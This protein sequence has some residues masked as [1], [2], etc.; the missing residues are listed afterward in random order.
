MNILTLI[1]ALSLDL[2]VVRSR[3]VSVSSQCD[4]DS[5]QTRIGRCVRPWLD[6][7][8]MIRIREPQAADLVFPVSLQ[9]LYIIHSRSASISARSSTEYTAQSIKYT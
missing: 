4:L 9:L 6:L 2:I 5:E 3:T 8:E 1:F 7:W